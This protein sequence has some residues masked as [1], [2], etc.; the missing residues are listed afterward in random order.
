MRRAYQRSANA[1]AE[2]V[3]LQRTASATRIRLVWEELLALSLYQVALCSAS[4]DVRA[5]ADGYS[6][7]S[8]AAGEL[9]RGAERVTY[10]RKCIEAYRLHTT[11]Y[12]D[13]SLSLRDRRDL[14]GAR[15]AAQSGFEMA[16]MV[17]RKNNEL[18]FDTTVRLG[19]TLSRDELQP[20]SRA[21]PKPK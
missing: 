18:I 14:K 2:A 6:T 15:E 8:I 5:R 13:L 4:A 10:A 3:D 12:V 1:F 20:W 11:C 17:I 7:A 16:D 21:S 9:G 19:E